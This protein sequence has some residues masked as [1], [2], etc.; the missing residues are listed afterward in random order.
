MASRLT[1]GEPP[2]GPEGEDDMPI[3]EIA[4]VH[5]LRVARDLWRLDDLEDLLKGML[6]D[7]ELEAIQPHLVALRDPAPGGATLD[8]RERALAWKRRE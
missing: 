6:T 8:V 7:A 4:S 3:W 1:G 2:R 5:Q